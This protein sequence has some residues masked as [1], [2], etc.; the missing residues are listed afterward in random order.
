MPRDLFGDV[1]HPSVRV[2]QRKWYTVPLS[3][4]AHA[5]VLAAIVIV[6]LMAT[7]ALPLPHEE[8]IYSYAMP[9]LPSPP[10]VRPAVAPQPAAAPSSGPSI[11]LEAPTGIAP[12]VEPVA[13]MD[14]PV[15]ETGALT[16]LVDLT[17]AGSVLVAPEPPPPP[18][19]APVR[20]GGQIRSPEK[21]QDVAPIY[22]VIAQQ[23]RVEGVV[24]IE[25]LIGTDGRVQ[26]ARVLRAEP[27]LDQAALTA[28]RQ[29]VYRP[30]L[31]N[32]IPVPVV[33]TVTVRFS[34]K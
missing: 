30:T 10:P 26:D 17:G 12:E 7:G 20:V 27:L 18:A 11:P 8:L 13:A 22:P 19:P 6:P 4:A 16:G 29:W 21:V 31:L 33:M 1:T 14:L 15:D 24:I 23:A 34:L 5:A 25:A 2:G 32:G 28:V 9:V 3:L